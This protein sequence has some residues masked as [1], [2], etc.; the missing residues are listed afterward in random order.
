M[1]ETIKQDK[2]TD[3]DKFQKI[4]ALV[5]QKDSYARYWEPDL[6]RYTVNARSLWGINYGMWPKVVIDELQSKNKNPRTFNLMLP[7]AKAFIGSIMGNGYDIRYAPT[8]GNIDSLVL[9]LQE[10][11][12]SDKK[13]MFWE[14]SEMEA[15]LDST[16]GVGFESMYVSSKNHHLG[17]I[18][19]VRRNP[20]RILMNPSW[21]SSNIDDL[22]DWI[23]WGKFTIE[24]IF[25][26]FPLHNDRLKELMKREIRDKTINYGVN[27][28][29]EKYTDP[30]QKWDDLHT[31]YEL[32]WIERKREQWEYD[33]KNG[34]MFPDT[35]FSYHSDEDIAEKMRYIQKNN[36]EQDDISLRIR[37]KTTKYI[38]AICPTL[39]AELMLIDDP[40]LIQC[41]NANLFPI[42][43]KMDGQ[44]Q[45]LVDS[46]IDPNRSYNEYQTTMDMIHSNG[47]KQGIVVDKGL[48]DGDDE[49]QSDFEARYSQD[50]P[51]LFAAMGTTELLGSNGGILKLPQATISADIFRR[52]EGLLNL[53]DR[54][55]QISAEEDSRSQYAGQANK[56]FENKILAG[57][58]GKWYDSKS[59]ELHQKEKAAAYAKQ[60]KYTYAGEQREFGGKDGKETITINKKVR[61]ENTGTYETHDDISLLPEIKVSLILSRDGVDIR[62]QLRED[63]SSAI[64]AVSVDPND[65]VLKLGFLRG[66]IKTISFPDEEKEDFDNTIELMLFQARLQLAVSIKQLM[67]VLQPSP[68]QIQGQLPG[69]Q[70]NQQ[71]QKVPQQISNK[72]PTEEQ[73]FQGTPQEQLTLK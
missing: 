8:S 5:Q 43:I 65:R 28:G 35:S 71:E 2:R 23:T 61:N 51:L 73:T 50:N 13:E 54:V 10:M 17:N 24:E 72:V 9:K 18:A 21:K 48:F 37:I 53:M 4:M 56:M 32:H 12:Y 55:S 58:I 47:G 1:F 63:L 46:M 44:Y 7:K 57:K 69:T 66:I 16:C 59:Y 3:Q 36:L 49:L 33:K 34:C 64:Q 31:V 45:G 67:A 25:D 68:G 42:G 20:R 70:S 27:K 60:A 19:W 22:H 40:D 41:G 39:D 11:Y 6:T 52:E 29:I 15:I 14:H 26:I 38:R 62:S 30:Q